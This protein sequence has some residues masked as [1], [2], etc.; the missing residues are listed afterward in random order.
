MNEFSTSLIL[1]GMP[2]SGKSTIGLLL[3]K[4]LAKGFV[5]TDVLIQL[6]QNKKLQDIVDQDGYLKL[7]EIEEQVLLNAHYPNHIIATGGSA[8]Y[9]D[10]SMQHLR[11]FGQIVFLD[12]ALATLTERVKNINTRGLARKPKQSLAELYNERRLLYQQFANITINC[13]DK[14]QEQIL[15]E[16]IY[17]E[18]EAYT[19]KDA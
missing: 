19:E 13:S 8:V 2:G 3:A 16:I 7:R 12:V 14:S 17:Q 4:A 1:I 6:Q 5:D 10:K 9:S 18:A 11:H 15:E